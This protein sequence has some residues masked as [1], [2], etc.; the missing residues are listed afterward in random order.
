MERYGFECYWALK[1]DNVEV[2]VRFY[3]EDGIGRTFSE[4]KRIRF[5]KAAQ[6]FFKKKR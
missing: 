1:K 2:P 4:L 5:D 3:D 6:A